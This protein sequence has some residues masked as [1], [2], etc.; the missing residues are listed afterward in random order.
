MDHI[1]AAGF[2][3]LIILCCSVV[4]AERTAWNDR[5]VNPHW[6][7]ILIFSSLSACIRVDC[8]YSLNISWKRCSLK[9]EVCD[10]Q[11]SQ[12]GH[13]VEAGDGDAANVVVVQCPV[14]REEQNGSI[15]ICVKTTFLFYIS[16]DLFLLPFCLS[17]APWEYT[18]SFHTDGKALAP[19]TRLC[20][21]ACKFAHAL[22]AWS[23]SL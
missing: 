7:Y 9:W 10:L 6:D 2:A 14:K 8:N 23:L 19:P 21:H 12:F 17:V 11:S 4:L 18:T 20:S 1:P 16:L 3:K 5:A 13:V 15:F 22:Q